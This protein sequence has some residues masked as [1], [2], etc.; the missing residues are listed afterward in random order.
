MVYRR[1]R[2]YSRFSRRKSYSRRRYRRKYTRKPRTLRARVRSIEQ[3]IETKWADA[4][5]NLTGIGYNFV[6]VNLLP[7]IDE[8]TGTGTDGDRVGS[9]INLRYLQS[10]LLLDCGDQTQSVRI[11][12]V[13]FP[14]LTGVTGVADVV[15]M[16]STILGDPRY[17]IQSLYKR[18]GPVKYKVLF[19][20]VFYLNTTTKGIKVIN[21][22]TVLPKI[23]L[24]LS[25]ANSAATQ[26]EKN[27][28]N[29]YACSDSAVTPNPSIVCNTRATYNDA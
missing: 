26:P 25:Y 10:R 17:P 14:V 24:K 12:V 19:D 4:T 3:S 6:G 29:L 21:F 9:S 23:G 16:P 5:Q 15:Q 13:M 7:R 11:L 27:I 20:R 22:K 18:N 1:K 28:I 8:G 2:S